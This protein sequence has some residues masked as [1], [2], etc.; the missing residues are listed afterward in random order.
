MGESI[1]GTLGNVIL[2]AHDVRKQFF[3]KGRDSA[4]DF[5]A[6][7][8]CN[9]ALSAG[10][11]VALMGRSGSGKSTL[12]NMLAGLLEPTDGSVLLHDPST[13]VVQDVYALSDG[14]LSALRNRFIG[15]VPQ[16]QT[17]LHSLTVVQNVMLPLLMY[18]KDDTAEQ[19]ALNLLEKLGIHDLADSYPR[20]LSGGELRRMAIARA[21]MNEPALILA[22]EPTSDLDDENT[23][24]ALRLLREAADEGAAV[25]V[26]THESDVTAYT[27]RVLRMSAGELS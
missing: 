17:A 26:V 2:E 14:E 6:V 27:D 21:L 5:D 20:E 8:S 19:R 9:L 7:K 25:L 3:R 10:E 15:V 22:D 13:A 12:L 1:N 24:T 4:R 11:F 18:G 23:A 16:G